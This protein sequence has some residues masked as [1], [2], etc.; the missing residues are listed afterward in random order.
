MNIPTANI[1]VAFDKKVMER[2]FSSGATY[3][4]LVSELSEGLDNVLLFDNVA[5]P[6]FI[7]L[8]H[9]LGL[10]GGFKIVLSFIDPKN[11]FEKRFFTNN[12][13]KIIEGFSNPAI[14]KTEGFITDKPDDVKQSQE[15]Y[16]KEYVVQYKKEL[17]KN[18][19]EREIYVAYGTGNNL[20]L[21]SGPHRTV[22]TN[23]DITVE[24]ARKITLTLTPTPNA[25]NLN[26]RRGAYNEKVNLNLLGLKIRYAGESQEIKF[27]SRK[28]YDPTEYISG[29]GE[30]S[31]IA[32]ALKEER[33]LLADL[34]F[35]EVSEK[36]EKFDFHCMVVDAIRSYVQKATSNKNV[37]V[38]LPNLNITCRQAIK[39][40]ARKFYVSSK[41]VDALSTAAS[42]VPFPGPF[43]LSRVNDLVTP[44]DK[45]LGKT[46][47]F[48]D[49]TLA[50][51][52]LR[53]HMGSKD[54]SLKKQAIPFGP[55][56]KHAENEKYP[57]S[58]SAV[59]G[60]YKERYFTAVI[61]KTDRQVP[62][63]MAVL[64]TVFDKIKKLSHESYKMS[65][66]AVVNETEVNMM[67]LW[68]TSPFNKFYTF[69]GYDSF[70]GD[71]AIIVGDLALIKEYLYGSVN[72]Q[73]KKA[74]VDELRAKAAIAIAKQVKS[75]LLKTFSKKAKKSNEASDPTSADYLFA[76]ATQVPLHPLDN[77]A[78]NNVEYN[79]KVR[80]IAHP[81]LKG[82]GSFGD[83]SYLPD[84]FAY[85][86][87]SFSD[88]E[89]E[90]IEENGIPVFRYNTENPNTI[91]M[92]FKFGAIYFAL[93]KAGYQ[94]EI[95]RLTSAVAEG[96]LPTGVGT[97]PIRERG[98]A[99]AYLRSKGYSQG[100]GDKEKR[101]IIN[102]LALRVSPDLAEDLDVDS[103]E[104]AADSLAVIVEELEEK[105]LHGLVL[106]DQQL[107]GNPNSIMADFT[108]ELY[109]KALQMSIT[110]LPLFHISKT[111]SLGTPCI[112][113][114]Q[115]QPITQSTRQ[116]S[117]SLNKF[118]SGLYK[119]MGFK[120]TI[121]TGAAT[122]EFKLVKNAPKFKTEE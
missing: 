88:K 35:E 38:L 50:A 11:E 85:Q 69:G 95:K 104:A 83:I 99:I 39:D 32:N 71:S 96:V 8:E 101:D 55:I 20:D 114:G 76:A 82:V 105:N 58:S 18:I 1:V 70:E 36:L 118:F 31:A 65:S 116:P 117:T 53:M 91:D 47:L 61:D 103:S 49:G 27:N 68:T 25:L 94:K 22:M 87:E 120:H 97:F 54:D 75:G 62:D 5:N 30:N 33:K 41:V 74:A 43:L 48:V 121:T 115:D 57:S 93:L 110:T 24:G 66:L 108:E 9:S 44:T 21:W 2:L 52:G 13:T 72:L 19:G 107:P 109:R 10:G 98:A 90:Y 60:Y 40:E 37:I 111:S 34:G 29:A 77:F 64:Q 89:K 15:N 26:N 112:F 80:A 63:H 113:F 79:K 86:D 45:E 78:L 67:N 23:A 81:V 56:A 42:S 84:D 102:Q 122:S 59:K 119:I 7:S 106:V 16:S 3:K 6:N 46:E 51:F 14:E 28:P 4:S 17:Q 100:L 73:Q 12:P 92:K